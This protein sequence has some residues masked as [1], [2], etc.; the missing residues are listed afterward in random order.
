MSGAQQT[1]SVYTIAAGQSFADALAQGILERTAA[2]PLLLTDTT[3]LLPSRRACRTLREAFL[4][5]SGGRAVLL[6][7]MHPIG[8]VDADEMALFLAAGD[9]AAASIDIPPA[10]SRLERQLLLAQT[11]Q[12]AGMA[13]SFDQAV[14]LALELG[15]FLD[16]VQTERLGFDG[17]A[18]LVPEEFAGHWQKTLEFLKILTE[19]WPAILK[20]RGVI[21]FAE[22]RNRLLEAQAAAWKKQPP[23]KPVIAVGDTLTATVPAAAELLERAA[24]LPQGM[25]VL[26]GLDRGM[27]E[28]SWEK[29]SEDHPQHNMKKLLRR[30]GME[31]AG[32]KDWVLQKNPVINR[33]RVRLMSEAMR[34]ADT[35]ENWRK[36]NS[37]DISGQALQGLTRIDCATPQE[38]AEVIA[39]AM[40]E[41]LE[42]PGKTCALITP[43]RRL[44]RRVSL[45]LRRWDIHIDDS[46]GQP[47]TELAIGTWL[48]LTAE[49]AEEELAPVT[50]LSFLK[51][52]LLAASMA[53]DEL[54][55]MVYLL[56]G[57]VLR[58]PR[59]SRGFQGLRDA[60]AA[61]HE[62]PGAG[63]KSLLSWI[64]KI[65]SQMKDFVTL[66]AAPEEIPFHKILTQHI[67]MAETLAATRDVSGTERL[68]QGEAGE[69]AAEFLNSL[70][71]SSRDVP[72]LSPEHY[73]SLLGTL[74]KTLTVRPRYGAHPRL[75]I[76]GQIEARLYCADMVILGGLN[77]GT[78]P[79]LPAHD[80]W[81]SRPMRR[82]FGLPSPE[83]SISLAAHDFV[84]AAT[85]PEV[86]ITRARKV[87]GTPT[88]PARWLLRL[89][90]VL[91][92][93]GL[94]WPETPGLKYRRWVRLMDEPQE[95]RPVSRPAPTPPA[96]ARP[97]RLSV[98]KIESWMRDPYQIYAKYVL[99]LDALDPV[100]ADPGGAERG[101]FIH[102][103]LEKFIQEFPDRLPDD[104]AA[105][106]LNFGRAAL[107]E[108]RIPQEVEAFWWP[109]FEKI[110]D[111]FIRQERDWR[112]DAKPYLTEISGSWQ[113]EAAGGPFTL[114]GKA[115]RIDKLRDGSYAIIDYKSGFTPENGD[116][117]SGLSPQLPLEALMLERGGFEKIPAGK[118]S[119]LVYWKVTGSGQKPVEKKSVT[120]KD[121][122]VEQM[123]ADAEAGL[124]ALVDR[125]DDA[126]TPYL[127]QPRA[128][129]RPRFSDYEHL[130]RTKEWG[131]AGDDGGE[132]A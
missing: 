130:A 41:V 119:A 121:Y 64:D 38:E 112:L 44:A 106:L 67:R 81:M 108:M 89:E 15:H 132:A 83:K 74:L 10:V 103:A 60:A 69:T 107:T 94:D 71:K 28:A 39:F 13:Q 109:R 126:A 9:D 50:L 19:H 46:G 4:R 110:A 16:E 32:V 34:P 62:Q 115:D 82:Q 29:I 48:M 120:P 35:T 51:H 101:T 76:L 90:T 105:Q 7:A 88:V 117:K 23:Q 14:A 102:A 33:H 21:D 18:K 45:S 113:F 63:K 72:P 11:I 84:Q 123:V 99:D 43:D 86:L 59:P 66:M 80:P 12:K 93:V 36:L 85:A 114:T 52:P 78:W 54:R 3:I 6:P 127:S 68:W 40:R 91:K 77:E 116:V 73:V 79:D 30:V 122:S 25:L 53:P 26:P 57:L 70:L 92:A 65:E 17:L 61:L 27:D 75:S 58:G 22:R 125:F 104:A 98:T 128:D 100:D 124:K 49:M 24:R 56:D 5:L 111:Q 2:D 131:V 118:A 42:T 129:A 87:D 37:D 1:P 96:A 97:R 55:G 8:D 47:L 20:E 31:R 95:I